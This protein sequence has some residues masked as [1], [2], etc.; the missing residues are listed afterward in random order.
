MK[1]NKLIKQVDKLNIPIGKYAIT[2]SAV[3]AA[4]I[5]REANDID[6]IVLPEIWDLL[7][8]KYGYEIKGNLRH[9]CI[10][11]VE[12][13]GKG[14]FFCDPKIS[15]VEEQIQNAE[16]IDGHPFVSLD[17]IRMIK[18]GMGRQKDISD[19]RLIDS[20]LAKEGQ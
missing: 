12:I 4:H 16:I 2:S 20:Y 17:I 3:L 11:D 18:E 19:V 15:T 9:I 13:L 5:I 7:A 6:I 8:E 1:L 14:S 10:G